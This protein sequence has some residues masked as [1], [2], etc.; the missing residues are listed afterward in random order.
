MEELACN[1]KVDQLKREKERKLQH[2][3]KLKNYGLVNPVESARNIWLREITGLHRGSSVMTIFVTH[4]EIIIKKQQRQIKL[5]AH[6]AL[7][8]N[9]PNANLRW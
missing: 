2:L 8:L 9:V 6:Q 3:Q 5:Q 4:A 7:L 1:A